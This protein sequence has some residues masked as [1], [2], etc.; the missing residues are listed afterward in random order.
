VFC[1]VLEFR[2]E[3]QTF[4]KVERGNAD[5]SHGSCASRSVDIFREGTG[6]LEWALPSRCSAARGGLWACLIGI[7]HRKCEY[8]S[9][10]HR[11]SI[12]ELFCKSATPDP[13]KGN[14]DGMT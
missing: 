4:T 9:G 7:H 11:G 12:R 10:I 3:K 6:D 8:G 2:K 5:F 14:L 13:C 1:L